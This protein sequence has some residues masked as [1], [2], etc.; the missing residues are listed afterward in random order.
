MPAISPELLKEVLVDLHKRLNT[1]K[2]IKT[3][4]I[5]SSQSSSLRFA[6]E[7]FSAAGGSYGL[8]IPNNESSKTNSSFIQ[9]ENFVPASNIKDEA[10]KLIQTATKYYEINLSHPPLGVDKDQDKKL[11]E[12]IQQITNSSAE[13]SDASL[14]NWKKLTTSI[15]QHSAHATINDNVKYL[16]GALTTLDQVIKKQ[17]HQQR[18]DE[19]NQQR[20]GMGSPQPVGTPST[21]P[22]NTGIN[23]RERAQGFEN[24]GDNKP[25]TGG[26]KDAE[27]A[28]QKRREAEEKRKQQE[29]KDAEEKRRQQEAKDAEE[30]RRQQEAKDQE[31]KNAADK[32]KQQEAKDAE[33]KRRQQEA[34]DQEEKNAG[35]KRKQ[36]EA[37]DA[38]EKRRQQEAKDQEKKDDKDAKDEKKDEEKEDKPKPKTTEEI[39]AED[40]ARARAA[41]EKAEA[42]RRSAQEAADK[43]ALKDAKRMSNPEMKQQEVLTATSLPPVKIN[44]AAQVSE[45]VEVAKIANDAT[46]LKQVTDLLY[47]FGLKNIESADANQESLAVRERLLK[48]WNTVLLPLQSELIDRVATLTV[49]LDALKDSKKLVNSPHPHDPDASVS[50]KEQ[51]D[52]IHQTQSSLDTYEKILN[53]LNQIEVGLA[54]ASTTRNNDPDYE[55]QML[56][57][58]SVIEKVDLSTGDKEKALKDLREKLGIKAKERNDVAGL[59]LTTQSTVDQELA[60]AKIDTTKHYTLAGYIGKDISGV[61]VKGPNIRMNEVNLN[62]IYSMAATPDDRKNFTIKVLDVREDLNV[63]MML[64]KFSVDAHPQYGDLMQHFKNPEDGKP[65]S[66]QDIHKLFSSLPSSMPSKK[67]IQTLLETRTAMG[68]NS[69]AIAAYLHQELVRVMRDPKNPDVPGPKALSLA[70]DLVDKFIAKTGGTE[71]MVLRDPQNTNGEL[72][73]AVK[74][75]C[76]L[77]KQLAKTPEE[78]AM[79][80]YNDLA[81]PN[82]KPVVKRGVWD[83]MVGNWGNKNEEENKIVAGLNKDMRRVAKTLLRE[84]AT[85]DGAVA[86]KKSFAVGLAIQ[87]MGA[88][89][90]KHNLQALTSTMQQTNKSAAQSGVLKDAIEAQKTNMRSATRLPDAFT[91]PSNLTPPPRNPAAPA[92]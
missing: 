60:R 92:A 27:L 29:A 16:A 57:T 68:G 75:Y 48:E 19:V 31:E 22:V 62:T 73:L 70:K 8:V 42:E 7:L 39:A 65:L 79:Y 89:D 86:Q 91:A 45:L 20:A 76:E 2:E 58:A 67:E 32:R 10:N 40:A 11:K 88:S 74:Y 50:Q 87:A 55:N 15:Q 21:T 33:E 28:A 54:Q 36:Q 81:A 35:E 38:E 12:F 17:K 5:Q 24:K 18:T 9:N 56:V 80:K 69:K 43:Q 77:Q 71:T 47:R 37:K 51:D 90:S 78:A 72:R 46:Q 53:K 26:N 4:G 44:N 84:Q 83:K 85:P 63:A 3:S 41:E 6:A 34:K 23:V 14:Q 49:L 66:G 82:E 52:L 30:K 59:E 13:V 61:N 25:R 64:T 1:F